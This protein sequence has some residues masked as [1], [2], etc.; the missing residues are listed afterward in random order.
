[1][2]GQH[3]PRVGW[4]RLEETLITIKPGETITVDTLVTETGLLHETIETVLNT[5]TKAELFERKDENIF[6][7][8]R[9]FESVAPRGVSA[10]AT[11]GSGV[12]RQKLAGR[13][14]RAHFL[15]VQAGD[16]GVSRS[17]VAKRA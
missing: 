1:M 9:L 15:H 5:L 14:E 7:R 11:S 16:R 3:D 13:T 4:N 6:I 17:P 12:T 8:R 2:T 10:L